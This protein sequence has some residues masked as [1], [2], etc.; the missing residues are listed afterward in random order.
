MSGGL[1]SIVM[2]KAINGGSATGQSGRLYRFNAGDDI[3]A[4]KGELD[5]CK[6]VIWIQSDKEPS[7]ETVKPRQSSDYTIA[8]LREMDL[9]EK[10]DSFF[11]GDQRSTIDTLR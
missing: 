8:E 2:Y 9:S 11:E 1:N 5:H 6:S 10:D 3:P 4:F 7:V